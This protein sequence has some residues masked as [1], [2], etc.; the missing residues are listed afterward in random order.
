MTGSQLI[1]DTGQ[2]IAWD[3]AGMPQM[4]YHYR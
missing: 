2:L 3:E 4:R 1:I